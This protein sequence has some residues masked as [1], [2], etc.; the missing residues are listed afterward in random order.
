MVPFLG[1]PVLAHILELLR[2]HHINEV[3]LTVRYLADQIQD[4]FGDGSHLGMR[5]FYAYE[6]EPLGTA[7]SVK[8][9]ATYLDDQSFLVI[10]GDI[11]TD[12]DLP[13]LIQ[14]HRRKQALVTMA[15]KQVPNPREYG[16]VLTDSRGRISQYIEKPKHE[17]VLPGLVNTGIYI[18]EPSVLAS[19]A[20]NVACDFSYDLFPKLL[21][22]RARLFGW[23]TPGYWRD[24]GSL[25]SYMKATAD[26]LAGKLC[27]ISLPRPNLNP[28]LNPSGLVSQL[29][30]TE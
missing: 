1:K 30:I 15:L 22:Q 10:S 26:A 9:A 18:M 19:L 5:L 3:V 6:E 23:T 11:I 12:I 25:Q 2:Q 7:G 20:P 8:N 4:Y 16:L 29:P 13:K 28:E 24:I 17:P 21:A 27:H 14:F